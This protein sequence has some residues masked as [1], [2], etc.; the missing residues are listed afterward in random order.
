MFCP[1]EGSARPTTRLDHTHVDRRAHLARRLA[2]ARSAAARSSP[3]RSARSLAASRAASPSASGVRCS[4]IPSSRPPSSTPAAPQPRR[5]HPR[6]VLPSEGEAQERAYSHPHRETRMT[7]PGWVR[8]RPAFASTAPRALQG[9]GSRH[10]D[11]GRGR[12]RADPSQRATP[13]RHAP[14]PRRGRHRHPGPTQPSQIE[15]SRTQL[16]REGT[17]LDRWSVGSRPTRTNRPGTA[18]STG[19]PLL[20][21][22]AASPPRRA[23]PRRSKGRTP[24]GQSIG[25]GSMRT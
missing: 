12:G 18:S 11:G 1:P 15:R 6:G 16:E 22:G 24:D 21:A 10:V 20:T 13:R 3:G 2:P 19:S 14:E 5:R 7:N 8:S 17:N 4:V 23:N 9:R 25:T